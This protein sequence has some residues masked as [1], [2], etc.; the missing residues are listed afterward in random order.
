MRISI[1]VPTYNNLKYLK[2]FLLSLKKNSKFDHEIILHINDGSDG[3]LD[4][5][6]NNKIKLEII[7]LDKIL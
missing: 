4:Y 6:I 5:A 1:I 2:F 3:T 7:I